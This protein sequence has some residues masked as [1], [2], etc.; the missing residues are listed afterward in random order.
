MQTM[1]CFQC[2]AEYEAGVAAC[3]ECG[4]GLV[5]EPPV[6]P[7][8]VGS[9][10]EEQLS[11]EFHD[12]AFE[13]RRMLDQLLTGRGIVHAWQGASMIVRS[14]D[15]DEVDNLV[16]DVEHAT[17]PTLDPDVE[18][19]VYEMSEWTAAQQTE[20]SN[21]LGINGIP[22]EFDASG[23]LVVHAED[24]ER[25]DEIL[26][27]IEQAA[28]LGDSVDGA[29]G[30][31]VDLDGLDVNE[32]LS[33]VFAA[34]DRLRRNARDPQGVLS[35]LDNAPTLES[36]RTPFGFDRI[37]WHGVLDLIRSVRELLDNDDSDDAEI[38]ERAQR[39]RDV[40]FRMI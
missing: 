9:D 31:P 38:E 39:L 4:V 30:G 24:E 22:H 18:H 17:L 10:D 19:T 16:E 5:P 27:D 28:E 25:I 3:L 1:W 21:R 11:Y 15:E 7:E 26:D 36:I 14:A 12:W 34:A 37:E 40:L 29:D 2:G 6:A 23:D 33:T 13:S 8:D 20:L 32:L 35:M